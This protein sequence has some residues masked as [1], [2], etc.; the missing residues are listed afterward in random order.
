M[1]KFL[2]LILAVAMMFALVACGEKAP[3]ADDGA[4]DAG[5]ATFAELEEMTL[6]Y[7]S[8]KNDKA[9]AAQLAYLEAITAATEGGNPVVQ[10]VVA[11]L[12]HNA[13]TIDQQLLRD[14]VGRTLFAVS[15]NEARPVY[16]GSLFE[17]ENGNIPIVCQK[18]LDRY[19]MHFDNYIDEIIRIYSLKCKNVA[20]IMQTGTSY[21]PFRWE[22]TTGSIV[23]M[24][25]GG[26]GAGGAVADILCGVVNPS[27]KLPLGT[28]LV[29][30][31]LSAQ[32][33]IQHSF[34]RKPLELVLL[35]VQH[36]QHC[37]HLVLHEATRHHGTTTDAGHEDYDVRHARH[38]HLHLQQLLIRFELLLLHFRFDWYPHH[39]YP[40]QDYR[41]KQVA[42]PT[43]SQ[44]G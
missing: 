28:R 15:D 26:E 3:A 18:G 43:R 4:A 2:A 21:L 17:V 8:T 39:D 36:Y 38:V 1:K 40:P 30:L 27:G 32:L 24:W 44:Q 5:P 25:L 7:S 31:R 22:K 12:G 37:Q 29:D 11:E 34:P 19:S 35:V 9:D 41:R 16:T 14:M 10:E 20:V 6:V 42:C 23:Q 13:I 33:R